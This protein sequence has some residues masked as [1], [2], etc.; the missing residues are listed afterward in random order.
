VTTSKLPQ[1][2]DVPTG[3]AAEPDRPIWGSD[4][5]MEMLRRLDIEY[6]AVLPGST[7]RG[8][9]DSAVNYTGN[10]RP[11]LL[12]CNHE[13]ICVSAA[14]GYARA[15]GR[16]MV[17]M[18]HDLVGLLNAGMTIYDAWCDRTPVIIVG[19][20]G[21]MDATAR[22][23]W[24][25]WIH[26]A[27]VQGAVFRDFTKWDDQPASLAAI[28]ASLLRAYRVA[29]TQ[30]AGPVYVC[31]D[32]GLQEA[33]LPQDL[34]ELPDV[35]RYRPAAPP[36]PD[37]G[38][39]EEAARRLVGAELPLAF[40]GST[41]RQPGAV[42]ALVELA[43]LL[44]MP[45]ADTG[46]LWTSFPTGHDLDLTGDERD[47]VAKADV[48]LLLDSPNAQADLRGAR[49]YQLAI[50][51]SL[52]ELATRGLTADQQQLQALDVPILASPGATLP[53]LVRACRARLDS[54]AAARIAARREAMAVRRQALV[55][56]QLELRQAMWDRPQISELR[57]LAEVWEAVRE[58]DYVFTN[59]R[60]RRM[61]PGVC[62]VPGPERDLGGGGG[63]A[64]G[65]HSGVALGAALAL[66]SRA[67]LPV[68]IV[69]DGDLLGSIQVLWT[70]AHYGI[71]SLWVVNNNRSYF[72]DEAHQEV[73]ARARNRP[74]ENRWIAQRLE[75][76]TVD[77]SGLARS[78]G[79]DAQGPIK[80]ASELRPALTRAVDAVKN[81]TP[82]LLDVW[83]ENRS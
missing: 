11:E 69:G 74:V 57:L 72:N 13:M 6:A 59:G 46:S 76:P 49:S 75:H 8:I 31:F 66:R 39:V 56:R 36:A 83:T 43:E 9:H 37:A 5:V 20:T 25:D 28:P 73:V 12:L 17:A 22:R 32:V 33:R 24:I 64:V 2:A 48:V 53:L 38:A 45:V 58:E 14:R 77:F 3:I 47:L 70:A 34:P 26:T 1:Q 60:L 67:A 81:G 23:P 27:N 55:L 61:G 65:A 16:P 54:R 15:S 30:P 35:E 82:T 21:P 52:D 41:G 44:A 29:V 10:T 50:G 78:L 4:L 68:G 71:P 42:A 19:G 51:V 62:E 63:A 40:A 79:V 80:D 18:L 7:F